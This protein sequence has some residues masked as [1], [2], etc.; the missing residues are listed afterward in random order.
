LRP[1]LILLTTTWRVHGNLE[2]S[3]GRLF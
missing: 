3:I 1:T 2:L